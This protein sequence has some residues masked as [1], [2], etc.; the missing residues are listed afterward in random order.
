MDVKRVSSHRGN[1]PFLRYLAAM[2]RCLLLHYLLSANDVHA[3]LHLGMFYAL[4]VVDT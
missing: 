3:L 1:L 4:Q 2:R